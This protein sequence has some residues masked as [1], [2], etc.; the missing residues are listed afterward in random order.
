MIDLRSDTVTVPS[1]GMRE[2]MMNAVV[3][4][5]VYSDDPTVNSLEERIAELLGQEAALFAPTG[6]MANQLGLRLLVKPG[7]EIITE[8]NSH[9]VRAE[10]GAAAVFSGITS[11][12]WFG[13]RGIL[14]AD[15]AMEIARPNSGP[16]L[17]STAAIAVENTHNF[18]GGSVQSIE[19]I[20][21]LRALS[22][23][24]GMFMHLD[25]ARLWNAHVATGVSLKEYGQHFDTVSV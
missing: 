10:L 18:G 2:A 22:K 9:I 4:D 13:N 3:G 15:D 14:R 6:S 11:R 7:E 25:G 8:T 20:A 17:V 19:E 5:D 21:K 1:A 12:T 16:Y 24:A 23:P